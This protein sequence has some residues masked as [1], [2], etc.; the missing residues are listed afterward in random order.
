MTQA[1]YIS[2]YAKARHQ[3][4]FLTAKAMKAIHAAYSEAGRKIADAIRDGELEDGALSFETQQSVD[5]AILEGSQDIGEAIRDGVPK[6]LTT[7]SAGY[8]AIE[9]GYLVASLGDVS[10]KI[11]ADGIG[12]MFTKVS[13]DSVLR[14]LNTVGVD[15]RI[16]WGR[17]PNIAK[18]FGPDMVTFVRAGINEG[19][20]LGKIAQDV[21][22][23][24]EKGLIKSAARWGDRLKPGT[25]RF[26]ARCP[27]TID[28]RA[29]RLARTE[30]GRG[31]EATALENGRSN[32]GSSG[33]YNWVRVNSVDWGCT[34][35]TNAA[36]G[37]YTYDNY[38]TD[39]HPNCFCFPQPVMKNGTEFRNELKKWVNGEKNETLDKWY[40]EKYLSTQI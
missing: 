33:F 25:A 36:K 34:C 40:T 16:F 17:V 1:E 15:G 10:G 3:W 21:T 12:K 8:A 13:G 28:D 23:Y 32:P 6:L 4:P 38:P 5:R 31:I 2:E 19:I 22:S 26:L 37:P 39:R 27:E 14:S 29:L 18:K 30:L 35:P 9:T 20:D 7:A 11:T 24:T